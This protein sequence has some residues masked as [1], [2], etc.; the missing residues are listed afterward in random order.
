MRMS[1][2]HRLC[3]LVPQDLAQLAVPPDKGACQPLA[4]Q[5]YHLCRQ[6]AIS[7]PARW[8]AGDGFKV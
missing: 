3:R 8:D 7:G 4:M 2:P 1:P 5:V 6:G